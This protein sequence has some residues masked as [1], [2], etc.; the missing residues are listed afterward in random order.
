[1]LSTG[2]IV[3][4]A[5]R[6]HLASVMDEL[7]VVE[8]HGP[9]RD[10]RDHDPPAHQRA[11]RGDGPH[12]RRRQRR[13]R[14]C[15]CATA[16]CSRSSRP[17]PT[18]PGVWVRSRRY[19]PIVV[20]FGP[21]E[22]LVRLLEPS[23]APMAAQRPS[24]FVCITRAGLTASVAL[25]LT[26]VFAGGPWLFA[27]L[28]CRDRA[29]TR[30]S[31]GPIA[32]SSPAWRRRYCVV[33]RRCVPVHARRRRAAHH[34]QRHPDERDVQ[35]LLP[36]ISRDAP[37][38]LRTAVVP[39][40]ATGSALLLALV[41][42]WIAGA[43]AEWSA[44]PLRRATRRDRTE[45]R[46]CSS[47]SPRS[48]TG[49][50][51]LHDDR[52]RVRGR[53]VSARVARVGDDRTPELVPRRDPAPVTGPAGWRARAR[54]AIVLVAAVVAPLLPGSRSDAVVRLPVAR[55]R[56]RRRAPEGDDAH[57]QHPGQA[58]RGSGARGVHGRHR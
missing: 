57:R 36:A 29:R 26:S 14:A 19:R 48:A 56:H 24:S 10:R 53:V 49:G 43:I 40:A 54:V 4:T 12:A 20:P 13:A 3:G 6:R 5:G 58:A 27:A 18:A 32:A 44:P 47:R 8:P 2:A 16:A 38:V 28:V 15:S 46:R 50:W 25:G 45:P 34:R 11:R 51:V 55:R 35:Q 1:M 39:V 41:A 52:V 7:A 42:L 17:C 31:R 23:R 21:D 33:R 9:D 30:C 37:H 22:S